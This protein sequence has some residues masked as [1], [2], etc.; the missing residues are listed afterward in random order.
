MFYKNTLFYTYSMYLMLTIMA[1]QVYTA[2]LDIGE[3]EN[4]R[5]SNFGG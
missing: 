5:Y 3:D 2:S 4:S 1:Q